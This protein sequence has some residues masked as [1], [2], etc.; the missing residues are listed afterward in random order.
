MGLVKSAA[1]AMVTVAMV[2]LAGCLDSVQVDPAIM[3]EGVLVQQTESLLLVEGQAAMVANVADTHVGVGLTSVV[4]EVGDLP[5]SLNWWLRSGRCGGSGTP[6]VEPD[7]F[8]TV[9]LQ[10][11]QG[12]SAEWVLQSRLSPR[13]TYAVEVWSGDSGQSEVLACADMERRG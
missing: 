13:G 7:L 8:P 10:E 2:A 11:G 5:D 4:A 3:W 12:G 9:D 6:L 1:F